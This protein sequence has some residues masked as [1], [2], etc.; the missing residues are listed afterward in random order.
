MTLAVEEI[1]PRVDEIC[2]H[3]PEAESSLIEVLHD[4]SSEFHYLPP[5]ALKRVSEN[6]GVPIAKVYAVATFYKGFSLVPR[7]EKVIRVCKGTTCH[8]RG[9]DRNIDEIKR[10]L[11]ISPGE[12][13]DDL[14]FTLE[15]VNCVGTCAMAPVIVVNDKYYGNA[16]AATVREI[17]GVEP[18]QAVSSEADEG[19][20][21]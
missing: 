1:T 7:G 14:R 3:Y 18:G 16:G 17:L 21:A 6:L 10:I 15:V 11:G 4:V 5:D 8:V 13:T 19:G 2:S 9:A 20:D 12:T